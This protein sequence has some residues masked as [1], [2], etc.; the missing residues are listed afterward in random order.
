[1]SMKEEASFLKM[2]YAYQD[3]LVLVEFSAATPVPLV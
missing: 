1:M 2:A 3:H